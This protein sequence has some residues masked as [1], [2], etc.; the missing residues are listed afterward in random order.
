MART[1]MKERVFSA[2]EVANICGVVNQ[3][4][5]NW[6]DKGHLEAFRT[7]GGQYRVYP[8]VLGSF[9]QNQG[10][11]LPDELRK[12]LE[13]QA[14][15]EQIL[16]ID[17]D[18]SFSDQLR[19][20]LVSHFPGF[21]VNQAFDGFEAGRAVPTCKPDVVFL[22]LALPGVDTLKLCHRIKE[23]E[24]LTRPL[25]ICLIGAETSEARAQEAGA[26]E[27]GAD[28]VLKKPLDPASL[29]PIINELAERR[30]T[31]SS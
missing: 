5:I 4:A 23:D 17:D 26:Y 18:R 10:M 16:V 6:I 11:R 31:R 15:I 13:E 24:N 8:D 30:A 9:L 7:P 20:V 2:H 22:N 12:I 28:V 1:K 29:P 19:Q 14:K 21:T 27:A 25:I 3:T